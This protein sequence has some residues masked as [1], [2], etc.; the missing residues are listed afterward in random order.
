[1]RSMCVCLS[2]EVK[3][4]PVA[5][6]ATVAFVGRNANSDPEIRFVCHRAQSFTPSDK[7]D[8][9]GAFQETYLNYGQHGPLPYMQCNLHENIC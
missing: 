9:N 2:I 8:N 3:L 5:V 4:K 6:A 1:M 7:V